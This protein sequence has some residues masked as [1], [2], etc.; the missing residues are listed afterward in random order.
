MRFS[1]FLPG[2]AY[3]FVSCAKTNKDVFKI[4]HLVVAKPF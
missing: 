4:V 1:P 3:V 2:D